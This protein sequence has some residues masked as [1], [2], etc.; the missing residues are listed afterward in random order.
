[1]GFSALDKKGN[2]QGISWS[3]WPRQAGDETGYLL[4]YSLHQ[5]L[6]W[7]G[8]RWPQVLQIDWRLGRFAPCPDRWWWISSNIDGA[9]R[10]EGSAEERLP[11]DELQQGGFQCPRRESLQDP[12]RHPLQRGETLRISQLLRRVR[13]QRRPQHWKQGPPRRGCWRQDHK[14]LW[15]YPGAVVKAKGSDCRLMG[16]PWFK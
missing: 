9:R 4:D 14:H 7:N 2:I 5:S 10:V 1:M 16:L 13:Q 6:R 11:A 8:R 12:D 3:W 15:L